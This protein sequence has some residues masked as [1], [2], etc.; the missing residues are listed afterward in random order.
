ME[1]VTIVASME[2]VILCEW[3]IPSR[4]KE[5]KIIERMNMDIMKAIVSMATGITTTDDTSISKYKDIFGAMLNPYN[6][7]FVMVILNYF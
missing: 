6:T 2:E 5:D 1:E 7:Q 3:G 4:K